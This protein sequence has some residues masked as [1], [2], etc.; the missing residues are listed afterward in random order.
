MIRC[1]QKPQHLNQIATMKT[2][3]LSAGVIIVRFSDNIPRYLLLRVFGYWDFP[4]GLIDDGEL[5]LAGAIREVEEETSLTGLDFRWGE[6]Y[7]ETIPYRNGRKVARY[8][9][10]ESTEGSVYLPV[11][12]ELG[13]PEHDEFKWMTYQEAQPILADRVKPVFEWAHRTVTKSC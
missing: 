9:L 5:P 13:H 12:P 2:N 8:Y 7:M 6:D 3:T 11:S 10:A 4:K 1:Q